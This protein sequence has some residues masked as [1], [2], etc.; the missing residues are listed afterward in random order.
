L[1]KEESM[2]FGH[3]LD[4]LLREILLANP[5]NGYTEMLKV[6]LSDGFYRINLNIDDILKLGVV[7][8]S[9]DPNKKLVALPLVLPM[10]WKKLTPAFCTATETATDLANRDL[11]NALHH[12]AQHSLDLTAAKLDSPLQSQAK[13]NPINP[14]PTPPSQTPIN[15]MPIQPSQL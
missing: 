10:G 15:T 7:F 4:R 14:K 2:Q 3:A 5:T 1:I 6:D 11:Q 9:S 8:P 12:P 13:L